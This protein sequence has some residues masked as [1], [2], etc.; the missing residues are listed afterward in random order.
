MHYLSPTSKANIIFGS[1]LVGWSVSSFALN[2]Y[3][4]NRQILPIFAFIFIMSSIMTFLMSF[5]IYDKILP[6][7]THGL[8][9]RAF[10]GGLFGMVAASLLAFERTPGGMSWLGAFLLLI[11]TLV[12]CYMM[13]SGF[14]KRPTRPNS[15]DPP[16][17]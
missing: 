13:Y 4:G 17:S 1:I 11:F 10:P 12:G 2:F 7:T 15:K 3:T 9:I 16:T 6:R 5:L 8:F 14:Y